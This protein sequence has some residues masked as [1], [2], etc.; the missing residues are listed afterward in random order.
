M[1]ENLFKHTDVVLPSDYEVKI[2]PSQI[3]KFFELPKI[4]YQEN[5]LK[6]KEDYQFDCTSLLLGTI[7]HKIYECVTNKETITRKEI[8]ETLDNYLIKNPSVIANSVL[9]KELYPVMSEVTVNEFILNTKNKVIETEISLY[10]KLDNGIYLAGTID[11][12]DNYNHIIDYKNVS[13]KPNLLS[14]PFNYKIQLLAYA[15]LKYTNT[16]IQPDRM[17]L[18]YTVRPTKTLPARCYIVTEQIT[19][20]DWKLI[21]DTLQLITES[22]I[23]V[24]QNPN[25]THLIFKSM[26]LK[27]E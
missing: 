3:S 1:I 19:D 6:E 16:S 20:K 22:I 27:K 24:K 5:I 9:I 23:A 2:S 7:L 14:I 8:D 17:T 12:V 13:T 11:R 15:Y 18:V 26:D 21:E 25:L 10:T 4:W